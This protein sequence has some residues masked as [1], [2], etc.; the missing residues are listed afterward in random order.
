M[1]VW[2]KIVCSFATESHKYLWIISEALA[3]E[4]KARASSREAVEPVNWLI[5]L[6]CTLQN[7]HCH[8]SV[9]INLV[10]SVLVLDASCSTR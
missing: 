9:L 5:R 2:L 6:V 1:A 10:Q 7:S 3:G 8:F 4:T